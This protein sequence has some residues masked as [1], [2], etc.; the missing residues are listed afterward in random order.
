MSET[1]KPCPFCGS[2]PFVCKLVAGV[3]LGCNNEECPV[4]RL[5]TLQYPTEIEAIKAWN[6]RKDPY[7]VDCT[8]TDKGE[9][10]A[11]LALAVKQLAR[12]EGKLIAC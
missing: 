4:S 3:H 11:A 7:T 9:Q 5:Y 2:N 1:L 6:I 10:K 12:A 8:H